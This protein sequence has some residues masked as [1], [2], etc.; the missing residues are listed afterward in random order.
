M[1]KK[2]DAVRDHHIKQIM[3]I[4]AKQIPYTSSHLGI[5]GSMQVHEILY[6]IRK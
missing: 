4:S 3:L 5:L 1:R 2:M 6:V